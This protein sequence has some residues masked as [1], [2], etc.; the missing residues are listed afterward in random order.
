MSARAETDLR[1]HRG[2]P[3]RQSPDR[4]CRPITR[5]LGYLDGK[6]VP[7]LVLEVEG[8]QPRA[9][10]VGIVRERRQSA[11]WHPGEFGQCARRPLLAGA[12][13]L[14]SGARAILPGRGSAA[15]HGTMNVG[16]PAP[17]VEPVAKKP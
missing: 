6:Q 1:L 16:Q 15:R 8:G 14:Q 11:R 12:S 3:R 7:E 13:D 2:L 9:C 5:L 4:H 10:H 17:Q